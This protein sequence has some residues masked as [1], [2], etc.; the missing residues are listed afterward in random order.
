MSYRLKRGIQGIVLFAVGLVLWLPC[1]QLFFP[2][3]LSAYV[4][5]SKIAKTTESIASYQLGLWKGK[6]E[7]SKETTKMRKHNQE[8]DFMARTFFVWALANM[9]LRQPESKRAYLQVM[10]QIIQDTLEKE[11]KHTFHYFSMSYSRS[12]PFVLQP[13]RSQFLD[14]EIAMM[15]AMRRLV[16]EK[17]SYKKPL[18]E[19]VREMVRRMKKSPVLSAESY[20]DES[21]T[22]CNTVALAAIRMAD[23]LD[24]SDHS[25]FF[26]QWVRMAKKKLVHPKTGLLVSTYEFNGKHL[27][28]PEGSTIWMTTHNLMLIDLK[29]AK[30]QYQL[31][32]KELA[33]NVLGFGFAGE[34]PDSWRGQ[35]DVDSGPVIPF[36]DVSAGSSGLAF[37][38]AKAFRDNT[39]LRSLLKTLNFAAFPY[40]KGGKLRFMASNQVGDA[41]MLY[42]LVQGPIWRKVMQGRKKL[43]R[44]E[45]QR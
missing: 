16:E 30:E 32:K 36:V 5:P 25:D 21:W 3:Q 42:A 7:R 6:Q 33:R 27:Y 39:Y 11:K 35:A 24:G 15:L 31:A 40:Q 22:F 20:P 13:A 41:V 17:P 38:A 45:V 23:Y 19:R 12:R 8:W 29:F 43:A 44:S 2:I 4:H 1:V 34:W 37:V 26:K 14:G 28:G 9:A 10:D 18:K